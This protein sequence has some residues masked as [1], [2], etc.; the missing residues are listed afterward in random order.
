[1]EDITGLIGYYAH[2]N[3]PSHHIGYLYDYAGSPEDPDPPEADH[4]QPV[5]AHPMG[6]RAT[7]I[8]ARCP[9][10]S[11]SR[12]WASTPWRR[13]ATNTSSAGR[14]CQG[15]AAPAQRQALQ[16]VSRAETPSLYGHG[17]PGRQTAE[18]QLHHPRGDHG[19]RRTQVHHAGG[20]NNG[21]GRA[22]CSRIPCRSPRPVRAASGTPAALSA[23]RSARRVLRCP[24]VALRPQPTRP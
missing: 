11:C 1:M 21:R 20:P 9:P 19:R 16:L 23:P 4:G 22:R 17:D 12:P 13:A 8:S 24:V 5:R 2:G 10:G 6:S 18:P 3:E 7:T 14:S 15:G